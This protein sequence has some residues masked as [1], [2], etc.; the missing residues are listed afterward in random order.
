LFFVCFYIA[1]MLGHNSQDIAHK[2]KEKYIIQDSNEIILDF[3]HLQ[4]ID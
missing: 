2:T 3:I 1:A 4:T